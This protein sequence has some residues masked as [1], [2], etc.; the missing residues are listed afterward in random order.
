MANKKLSQLT[1]KGSLSDTDIIPIV[2]NVGTKKVTAATVKTYATSGLSTV[3]TSGDY[4]DLVN[5]PPIPATTSDLT[6]D[7]GFITSNVSADII[8]TTDNVVDLGSP[9]NRFRH[10]YVGPGT[11]Y[12]GDI[13]LTNLNGKLDAKKVINPGEENEEEDETDSDAFSD[14]RGGG[15]E[16][17]NYSFNGNILQADEAT[18]KTN[19]GDLTLESDSDVFVKSSGGNRQ[20]KF[21]NLGGI[22]LPGVEGSNYNIGETEG[23]LQLSSGYDF[24]IN[25]NT[26]AG[27]N[28]TW[29]FQA[30]GDLK[31]PTGGDIVDA[32]GTSVLGGGGSG[33]STYI[34]NGDSQVNIPT[35]NGPVL[36]N[37]NDEK[38]WQFLADGSLMF[39]DGTVQTTAYVTG[40]QYGYI[41]QFVHSSTDNVDM[42]AV[43]VDSDGNSYVSYSYYNN[44][45]SKRYGGIV[46]LDSTGGVLWNNT[47]ASL[48]T[49]GQYPK[50][51][52]LEYITANATSFLVTIGTYYDN[53]INKDRGFMWFINPADG[54]VGSM[55]DTETSADVPVNIKDAVF[56]ADASNQAFAVVV[57]DTY[58]ETL[59]KTFTPL[60]G[61]GL[62]K[63]V[64]SWSEFNTSS[65]QAGENIYYTVGGNYQIRLNA[66][67][68]VATLDGTGDGLYLQV[69]TNQDGTYS[70]LRV[71]GYS[72]VIGSWGNP[73]NVRVLGSN[74]GGVDGVNDLTFDLDYTAL[75]NNSN[76]VEGWASNIQGTAISDVV[77][78]G[79]GD[80]DWS[81]EIGNTLTFN[82]Q[83]NRQAYIARLG[84]N[85][86][87]QSI[88]SAEYEQ[89]NT[90]VVDSSGNSYAGGYYWNGS[91]GSVVIK[92][93]IDGNQQ[94]AV[95]ID[96]AANTGN[97]IMS[98]DLLSDGN[99]IVVDEDGC[100]TKLNSSNGSIIW[101]V[102]VDPNNDIS[103]DSDFKG[104]AT[105]DGNYIFTNYEDDDYTLYVLCLSGTDGS[106][107]WSKRITRNFGGSN[108]EIQV[109]DDYDAQYIDCNATSVT[110]AAS[111]YLYFN[112]NSTRAGLIINFPVSGEN[113]DGTYGQ[114]IIETVTPGW[115]TESTTSTSA[116]I[117]VETTPV[118]LSQASPTASTNTFTMTENAIGETGAGGTGDIT[119]D[120]NKLSSPATGSGDWPNGVITLAPGD[121]SDSNY[122]DNGQFIN[123]Y[124]TNQYDA[125][126]IH[127]APG[128]GNNSTGDLILGVDNYHIDI[129]H[130]GSIYVRTD[131]QNYSWEFDASGNLR[132]PSGGDIKDSNGNSVVVSSTAEPR[133]EVYSNTMN[134]GTSLN[135]RYAVDT[136]NTATSIYLPT[137]P[138]QGDT[139][140]VADAG[141][142]FATNNLTI[143]RNNMTINGLENDMVLN[144]NGASIGMFWTGNTW[145][146]YQ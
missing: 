70:I 43:A 39:P 88:G 139:F 117:N 144:T 90:V 79:W 1:T 110:I 64:V 50:I 106:E 21:N 9:T 67:D 127:I 146:T 72:G 101:Q 37:V 63:L 129:N 14:I 57:G 65:V 19:D 42:E 45:E 142:A 75:Q 40:Q 119:F 137:G 4:N 36:I 26:N 93:D 83:L 105:P 58:D 131:N 22:E 69:R 112:N 134:I 59:S 49:N 100:V 132:L 128:S 136:T 109:Q 35:S 107:V 38:E 60:T 7:S 124:P 24:Y 48:N 33:P 102:R 73:V 56:G 18:I 96:P 68:T 133:F 44:S 47:L 89:L 28:R 12:I 52:S 121:A 103:W 46:K 122:A 54:S 16:L 95:H 111:T 82:Y 5:T 130:N 85:T 125:P 23:G 135:R 32:T 97:S 15:A 92:F 91:K 126:H 140:F 87:G 76:N 30:N 10:L 81:T 8:P 80:K 94:W 123:I 6:N 17:G 3:A 108:G 66:F 11:I 62:N 86:W 143:N 61:S 53:N 2:D 31:L 141:G 27:T 13:K 71:N 78:F 84:A 20:W 29:S 25:T 41:N 115:N 34:D 55:F 74:L 98:I 51:A 99:V 104:T 118:T 120:G 113:T 138:Q 116:T 77:G 145:R 114:Y